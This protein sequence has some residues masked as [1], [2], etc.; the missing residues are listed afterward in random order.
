MSVG[1]VLSLPSSIKF[2]WRL[3]GDSDRHKADGREEEHRLVSL[4]SDLCSV[5]VLPDGPKLT[6]PSHN[7]TVNCFVFCF[8]SVFLIFFFFSHPSVTD[9]LRQTPIQGRFRLV[10]A[11]RGLAWFTTIKSSQM[12][13]QSR[14]P[15]WVNERTAP[16]SPCSQRV[17]PNSGTARLG[18]R[19]TASTPFAWNHTSR[20][21]ITTA[22]GGPCVCVCVFLSLARSFV[23]AVPLVVERSEHQKR[24]KSNNK[25]D[26]MRKKKKQGARRGT[27]DPCVI[28]P[29]YR[30][31][32]DVSAASGL[33][34]FESFVQNINKMHFL[35]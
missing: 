13:P 34:L 20:I 21:V 27:P 18:S 23:F 33:A 35:R 11:A 4:I 29:V 31:G 25:N 1:A 22:P 3:R 19:P 14:D 28:S 26:V 15:S 16:H 5:C 30:L 2:I 32:C 12:D 9:D 6:F 17:L 7:V 24:S 10:V 8:V